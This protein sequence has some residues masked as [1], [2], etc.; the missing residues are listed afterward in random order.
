MASA[1]P[2]FLRLSLPEGLEEVVEGLAREVI[3]SRVSQQDEIIK[4]A[5]KHFANLA[6]KKR[7]IGLFY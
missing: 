5:E 7:K 6:E 3:R 1:A 2:L 4:F